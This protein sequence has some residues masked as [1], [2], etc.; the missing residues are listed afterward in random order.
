M[1]KS[2][3]R[4]Q[5]FRVNSNSGSSGLPNPWAIQCKYATSPSKRR[6]I[7]PPERHT[8]LGEGPPTTADNDSQSLR[9]FH[10]PDLTD[11]TW[12]NWLEVEKLLTA[13]YTWDAE[14]GQFVHDAHPSSSGHFSPYDANPTSNLGPPPPSFTST[15]SRGVFTIRRGPTYAQCLP[16]A[17]TTVARRR[18]PTVHGRS[19]GAHDR[20]GAHRA[21]GT[22]REIHATRNHEHLQRWRSSR[23]H[24]QE[25]GAELTVW[26]QGFTINHH[27]IS[28]AIHQLSSPQPSTT[29]VNPEVEA[30]TTKRWRVLRKQVSLQERQMRRKTL[31]G[32]GSD[33]DISE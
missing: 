15:A 13:G 23:V 19:G 21:R 22:R 26:N 33:A 24:R 8:I 20:S 32:A 5:G 1:Q 7:V 9:A 2:S 29:R 14:T 4:P 16:F 17:A 30:T 25:N 3:F 18:L 31:G 6:K 27:E 28:D 12:T 10:N 11:H